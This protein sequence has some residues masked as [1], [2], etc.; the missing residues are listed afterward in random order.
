MG[1]E[2]YGLDLNQP[3]DDATRRGLYQ[4]FLD[5]LLLCVRNQTFDDIGAFLDAARLFGTPKVQKLQNYRIAEYPEA[6]I[7]SSEDVDHAGDGKRIVR[8]TMFHTDESY[9][10]M[11]PK[12]TILYGVEVPDRGGDTRYV[13]MQAAYDALDDTVKSKIDGRRAIHFYGKDRGG[14]KVPAMSAAELKAAPPVSHPIARTHDET[15]KKAIYVHETMTETVEGLS[16][17]ESDALLRQLYDHTTTN[18]DFQY[19]HQWQKGD[20]VI[21]DDRATLHAAT[22]DYDEGQ[23]RLLYRTMLAGTPTA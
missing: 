16:H 4:G 22:A 13:N 6:G 1:A 9:I 10:A 14:R 20:F 23:R 2:I 3:L 21:W 11:P 17:D 15:G 19:H 5:H 8:G 7:V 18:P 12:A